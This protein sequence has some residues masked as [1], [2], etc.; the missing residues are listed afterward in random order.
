V[1]ERRGDIRPLASL[2]RDAHEDRIAARERISPDMERR[3]PRARR[4]RWIDGPAGER[5]RLPDVRLHLRRVYHHLRPD[6]VAAFR[7]EHEPDFLTRDG[8]PVLPPYEDEVVITHE[9]HT[10]EPR[11]H[12]GRGIQARSDRQWPQL[13]PDAQ[14]AAVRG[15]DV[16]SVTEPQL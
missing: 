13:A 16:D 12:A 11:E 10:R 9:P 3:D 4:S 5:E 7:V 1:A 2:R 6:P 14:V 8:L 15:C